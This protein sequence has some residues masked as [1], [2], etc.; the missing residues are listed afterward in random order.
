MDNCGK[1]VLV[2]GGAGYIGS[3]ACK[4]LSRAGYSPVTYDNLVCGHERAVKW[5][6]SSEATFSIAGG[7][8]M[9]WTV[10]SPRL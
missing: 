6:P 9:S 10:T 8:T 3:H 7:L 4:A 5:G 1:V 2:A